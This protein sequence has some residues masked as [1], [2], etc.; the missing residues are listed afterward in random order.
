MRCKIKGRAVCI[1][2]SSGNCSSSCHH[3]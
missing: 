3:L 2:A 1:L